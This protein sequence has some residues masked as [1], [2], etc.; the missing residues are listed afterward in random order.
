MK[1]SVVLFFVTVIACCAST[2]NVKDFRDVRDVKDCKDFPKLMQYN[3]EFFSSLKCSDSSFKN[4]ANSTDHKVKCLQY[5]RA[6]YDHK[7]D[8]KKKIQLVDKFA[9]LSELIELLKICLKGFPR[10]RFNASYTKTIWKQVNAN[11]RENSIVK[12]QDFS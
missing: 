7:D 11:L 2:R 9:T 12:I 8:T 3:A 5:E 4:G 10:H 6:P 1:I